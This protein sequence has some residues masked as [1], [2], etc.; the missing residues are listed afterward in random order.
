MIHMLNRK[1]KNFIQPEFVES[2]LVRKMKHLTSIL[3]DKPNFYFLKD[4]GMANNRSVT[5]Q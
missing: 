4:M 3:N 1:L 5:K 2:K